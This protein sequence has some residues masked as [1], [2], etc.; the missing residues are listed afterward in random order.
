MSIWRT[1]IASQ[2]AAMTEGG[3][4]YIAAFISDLAVPPLATIAAM[5]VLFMILGMFIDWIGTLLLAIPV[6]APVVER[7]GFD[8]I[9][10]GVLFCLTMQTFYL[11]PPFG[12][13]A[14]YLESVAPPDISIVEIFRSLVPFILIQLLCSLWFFLF[15]SL[16]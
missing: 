15:R 13:A 7:L 6:L 8:L 16:R 2:T 14:F 10:F 4:S 9:W 3:A 5:L 12:P 1:P 11:S